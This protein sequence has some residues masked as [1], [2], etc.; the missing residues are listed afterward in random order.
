MKRRLAICTLPLLAVTCC[1]SAPDPVPPPVIQVPAPTP[2]PT[3]TPTPAPVLGEPEYENWPDAPQTAGDWTYRD[4]TSLSYAT[5]GTAGS[6]ARF[7]VECSKSSR[8]IRLVRGAR[9]SGTVP[10]RIRTETAQRLLDAAPSADGR[11]M[12]IATLS[13]NDRLLDA[14]AL[15]RGR[16]AVETAGMDTLYLPAWPEITRV[17]EDC[18]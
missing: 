4:D 12:L 3:P 18:R 14:M 2:T 7:G 1:K 10:M 5:F 11:P 16:F 17:I 8:N 6:A 9:A 13:A 15:S